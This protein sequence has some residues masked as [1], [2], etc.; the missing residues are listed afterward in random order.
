MF[1][2][3]SASRTFGFTT[4]PHLCPLPP[5]SQRHVAMP[6][7]LVRQFRAFR[8]SSFE[9]P[10]KG[11]KYSTS[12]LC[13]NSSGIVPVR[14]GK[15]IVQVRIPPAVNR[16]VVQVARAKN[17]SHCAVSPVEISLIVTISYS[18]LKG[19]IP[20]CC[21]NS[22]PAYAAALRPQ[23]PQ[24]ERRAAQV[25]CELESPPFRFAFR[26]PSNVPLPRLPEP[27]TSR[28]LSPVVSRF[29]V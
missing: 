5:Q 24:A 15:P 14:V 9:V 13:R 18:A 7:V 11:T 25:Q 23:R 26:R 1:L 22:P 8:P 17:G 12:K 2:F 4:S 27:R 29:S 16:A 28:W 3:L 21:R 19:E 6:P 10:F 20:S